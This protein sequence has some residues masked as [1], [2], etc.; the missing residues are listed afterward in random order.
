LIEAMACALLWL[1]WQN[2]RVASREKMAT[3]IIRT[4]V[5]PLCIVVV[6]LFAMFM[7]TKIKQWRKRRLIERGIKDIVSHV[8]S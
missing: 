7:K 3:E 4:I 2:A 6:F 8:R 1:P 5:V